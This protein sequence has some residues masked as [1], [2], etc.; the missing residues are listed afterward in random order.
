MRNKPADRKVK[1][2]GGGGGPGTGAEIHFPVAH[3]EGSGETGCSPEAHGG[4][5]GRERKNVRRKECQTYV[6]SKI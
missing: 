5:H 2:G 1:E 3:G 6:L 4:H